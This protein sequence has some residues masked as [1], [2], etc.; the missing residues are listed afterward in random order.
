MV[1]NQ[2]HGHYMVNIDFLYKTGLISSLD[3]YFALILCRTANE[4]DPVML[5]SAALT[6]RAALKGNVFLDLDDYAGKVI[7]RYDD[8][9]QNSASLQSKCFSLKFPEKNQ[10]IQSIKNSGMAGNS[11]KYP[12]VYE[13]ESHLYLARYYDFQQRI[14]KNIVTRMKEKP[15]N[16]DIT[17][18][19]QGVKRLF[20]DADNSDTNISDANISKTKKNR[21]IAKGIKKAAGDMHTHKAGGI[22]IQ[23]K[24][25]KNAL[26]SK[27]TII[28]GGPGTGK[29]FICEKIIKLLNDQADIASMPRPRII[30][31]A[32]TGKAASKLKTGST[33]HRMLGS[34]NRSNSFRYNSEN[35]IPCDV[36]IIDEAS[37]IDIA[38]MAR[39]LEA[40]PQHAI[41]IMLGDKNQLASVEAGAVFGDICR[42]KII[43][44]I[45]INLD[46]NF[47]SGGRSGIDRLAKAVNSGDTAEVEKLLSDKNRDDICFVEI[48]DEA[49]E[50]ITDNIIKGYLPFIEEAEPGMALEKFDMFRILCAHRKGHYGTEYFNTKT[51]TILNS[52]IRKQLFE[53][54]EL[55]TKGGV[56]CKTPI[57]S[58]TD[59][60]SDTHQNSQ[61]FE[62]TEGSRDQTHGRYKKPVMVNVNDYNKKLFNGD[63]GILMKLNDGTARVFLSGS[64]SFPFSD[65][66][67]HEDAFAMTVHKS[68]GSEF[69]HVLF[70]IPEKISPVVTRELLYTGIT[71]AKKKITIAGTMEVIKKAVSSP[72]HRRSAI[73]ELIDSAGD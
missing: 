3:Y 34:T 47:R 52:Q 30:A 63:T 39:L 66:P 4:K 61:F 6:S 56:L 45:L 62:A 2:P 15:D 17:V 59:K 11:I 27:F 64:K 55:N 21:I 29:T 42:A 37:M 18:L 43:S 23:K 48:N 5:L 32:P 49:D 14:V 24:A 57:N 31:A 72:L 1:V 13:G 7:P 40:V 67:S 33:I 51:E 20:P 65:F 54:K 22:R 10:W 26:L 58:F 16:I 25:A 28:S 41:L 60:N 35:P 8:L 69:D 46:Y 9:K 19:N 70:V 44:R 38:L 36:V 12:L 73:T 68:Q 71:R 50:I 53:H